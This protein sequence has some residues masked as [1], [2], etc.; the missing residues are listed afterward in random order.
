MGYGVLTV[1]LRVIGACWISKLSTG[2]FSFDSY[3]C[4]S[5]SRSEKLLMVS[6]FLGPK[7]VWI[8]RSF[9]G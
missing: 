6:V 2:P 7:F 5:L 4:R 8:R 3:S 1:D 9:E